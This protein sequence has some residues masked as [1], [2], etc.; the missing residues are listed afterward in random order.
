MSTPEVHPSKFSNLRRSQ[1]VC[2]SVPIVIVK[3]D[4]NKSQASEETRTLIVSAHGALLVLTMPVQAGELLTL[5]HKKTQEE[6]VCRV[7]NYGPDQSGKREVGVEFEHPAPR[8]WRIAFPPSD[9]SPRSPD[10]KPPTPQ[11]PGGRPPLK[12]PP[13]TPVPSEADKKQVSKAPG[14]IPG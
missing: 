3:N 4:P 2:L 11:P 13:V 5:K 6:L 10:A 14:P 8:F 1:R 9:W 7:V 12:R